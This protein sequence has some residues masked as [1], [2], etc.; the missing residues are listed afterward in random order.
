[1]L[2]SRGARLSL[3]VWGHGLGARLQPPGRTLDLSHKCSSRLCQRAVNETRRQVLWRAVD[4]GLKLGAADAKNTR[5]T[6]G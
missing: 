2:P 3:T 5:Q 6:G 4:V 1:M